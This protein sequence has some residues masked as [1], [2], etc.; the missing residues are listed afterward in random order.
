MVG[1]RCFLPGPTKK[2]SLQNGEKTE[3]R[4]WASFLDENAQVQFHMD[5]THVAFLH[6]F[7]PLWRFFFS[8]WTLPASSSSFFFFSL[9]DVACLFF[10]LSFFPFFFSFNLLGR[11]VQFYFIFLLSFMFFFFRCD[12]FHGHDFYF[13][14]NLGDWIFF[15]IVHHMFMHI[16]S[17]NL[18]LT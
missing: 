3:E 4:N 9:L 5:F 11:L 6:T 13:L 8:S 17:F 14:I 12:F 1:S 2:F 7:F 10:F 18:K 16:T 15:F